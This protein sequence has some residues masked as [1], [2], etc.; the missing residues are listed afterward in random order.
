MADINCVTK[1]I[2][3]PDVP[4]TTVGERFLLECQGDFPA[5]DLKTLELRLE[6]ADKYK[7]KLLRAQKE[8]NSSMRF[9][10]LS[11]QVGRHSL[12]AVQLI[13]AQSSAVIPELTFEVRS[14]QDPQA[15]V[16]EPY[17]PL[18]PFGLM[19]PWFYW[20]GLLAI[21]SSVGILV[22]SLVYRKLQRRKLMQQI[23]AKASAAS[24]ESELFSTL[25]AFQRQSDFLL[26]P[27]NKVSAEQAQT[28]LETLK[29]AY[30]LFLSREY[31]IP[32]SAWPTSRTLRILKREHSEISE[33]TFLGIRK[34]LSEFDRSLKSE[35]Y[36]KDLLQ[37]TGWVTESSETILKEKAR[38]KR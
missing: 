37:I 38:A 25:R 9:E 10:V 26:N 13:D 23:L 32:A 24:P 1:K 15:P 4:S 28:S 19:I 12:R 18:G 22:F 8:S 5:F 16:Q 14:V 20:V 33:P 35:M 7:L 31:M 11:D 27:E 2:Q 3:E 36:A 34:L 21:L 29:S 30:R 17:G 6:A